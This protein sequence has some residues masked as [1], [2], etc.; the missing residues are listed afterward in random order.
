MKVLIIGSNGSIGKRYCAILKSLKV[1]YITYDNLQGSFESLKAQHDGDFDAAIICTPTEHHIEYVKG[2]ISLRKVFLCEKPLS[3][4]LVDCE[5]VKEYKNGYVVCNYKYIADKYK[6]P[7]SIFY[8][9][10]NTGMDGILWDACQ[11]LYLDPNCNLSISS[12]KWNLVI[13]ENWIRYRE[14]E[15]SYVRMLKDFVKG[16]YENLWTLE[17]GY[18]MTQAVLMAYERTK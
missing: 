3:K 2:L 6:P 8:D 9:Y 18:K 10:Y 15:D 5:E 17:D 7:Y 12:P 14:L 1:D 11:L 4:F 16:K 13:N